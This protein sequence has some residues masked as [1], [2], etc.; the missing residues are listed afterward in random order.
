MNRE[1][2]VDR[3]DHLLSGDPRGEEESCEFPEELK[4]GE[5][6]QDTLKKITFCPLP[7]TT[8]S[9]T[10]YLAPISIPLYSL[11]N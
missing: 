3:R 10:I 4:E 5:S 7:T 8:P 9:A 11:F 6:F 2:S 1:Y